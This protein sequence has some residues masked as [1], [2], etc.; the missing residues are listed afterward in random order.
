MLNKIRESIGLNKV[1]D[2]VKENKNPISE[3]EAVRLKLDFKEEVDKKESKEEENPMSEE[4]VNQ[5][6]QKQQESNAPQQIA[7][8]ER[9]RQEELK[10]ITLDEL[11]KEL[12]GYENQLIPIEDKIGNSFRIIDASDGKLTIDYIKQDGTHS[13]FSIQVSEKV[14]D[15]YR[16]VEWSDADINEKH[17]A[18][19]V[20]AVNKGKMTKEQAMQALEE[21]GRKDSK[22]YAELQSLEQQ[23]TST[24]S[25]IDDKKADIEIGKVG[26]T[27][28]EVKADGVYYQG[29]K[30]DNP[31]NKT[32]RQLIEDDIERRRKDKLYQRDPDIAMEKAELELAKLREDNAPMDDRVAVLAGMQHIK[33]YKENYYQKE[34]DEINAKSKAE[35]A[36]LEAHISSQQEQK[37][38]QSAQKE[39]EE[40]AEKIKQ[41]QQ[42]LQKRNRAKASKSLQTIISNIADRTIKNINKLDS[43]QR[44]MLLNDYDLKNTFIS[45]LTEKVYEYM[46]KNNINTITELKS[47][48]E[49]MDNIETLGLS[50][51]DNLLKEYDFINK[52]DIQEEQDITDKVEDGASNVDINQTEEVVESVVKSKDNISNEINNILEQKK[53]KENDR[54]AFLDVLRKI[55]NLKC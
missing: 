18:K 51:L 9:G 10:R 39:V 49:H 3:E 7:E 36:A 14:L 23:P 12:K 5:E 48:K 29:E 1:K 4:D 46:D 6:Q 25:N 38:Q 35:L 21:A 43:E 50:Y 53:D 54:D 22:A 8:I 34:V 2:K 33:Y 32:Y 42:E 44:K 11:K 19:Y 15:K 17:D 28:Y 31:E 24:Q 41:E 37:A 27:E 16:N 26:N 47:N 20:D 45:L 13:N 30:L 52:D 40:T 55:K